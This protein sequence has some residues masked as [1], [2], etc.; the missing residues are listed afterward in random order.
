MEVAV[1]LVN[2]LTEGEDRSRKYLPPDGA[3]RAERISALFKSAGGRREVTIAEAEA[4]GSVA[5]G[6]REV[7][8][9]VAAG[10]VDA[11]AIAV[12]EMLDDTGARPAFW[13]SYWGCTLGS[14]LPMILGAMVGLAAP[15]GG[16]FSL[17]PS[18]RAFNQSFYTFN[19]LNAYI[20]KG[21]G[22][23]GMDMT[24]VTLMTRAGDEPDAG[25]AQFGD[26][27]EEL[28]RH[29]RLDG[30][31]VIGPPAFADGREMGAERN[32]GLARPGRGSDDDMR[33]AHRF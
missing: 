18:V 28:L 3:G 32:E 30:G 11:A 24:F 14:L 7:F 1:G 10:D 12:N 27:V 6:L 16:L 8:E 23:Q 15:K 21:E 17:I 25:G 33:A 2:L 9:F 20:L 26:Q 4:F 31:S 19:S 5:A 29:Q 13:A 22:A